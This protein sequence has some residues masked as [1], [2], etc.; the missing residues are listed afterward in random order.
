MLFILFA[1]HV[2]L[3]FFDELLEISLRDVSIYP[4]FFKSVV[5]LYIMS[6]IF[7]EFVFY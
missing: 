4:F 1:S 7:M 5:F 6:P 2:F 3:F